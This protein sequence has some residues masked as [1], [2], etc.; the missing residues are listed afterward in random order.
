M[1]PN[2]AILQIWLF[3]ENCATLQVFVLSCTSACEFPHRKQFIWFIFLS[4]LFSLDT[5][6][7]FAYMCVWALAICLMFKEARRAHWIT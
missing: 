6:E 2:R 3:N 7:I 1:K 5:Y 4:R